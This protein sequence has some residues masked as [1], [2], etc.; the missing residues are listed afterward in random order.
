MWVCLK[1]FNLRCSHFIEFW[2]LEPFF[3]CWRNFRWICSKNKYLWSIIFC[4]FIY[5]SIYLWRSLHHAKNVH[6]KL[7][8][9]WSESVAWISSMMQIL[10]RV[11]YNTVRVLKRGFKYQNWVP[12][13][14]AKPAWLCED[15]G[16]TI[17]IFA[18][19]FYVNII[20]RKK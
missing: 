11:S 16:N 6:S 9:Y 5:V 8:T 15:N 1:W 2:T 3:C 12:K 17:I 4:S 19:K 18:V 20:A 13:T 10:Q 14:M 7:R